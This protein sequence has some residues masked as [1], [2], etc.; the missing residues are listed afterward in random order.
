MCADGAQSWHA[1]EDLISYRDKECISIG[2]KVD[3]IIVECNLRTYAA[4]LGQGVKRTL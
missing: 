1:H 4:L 3:S 2:L